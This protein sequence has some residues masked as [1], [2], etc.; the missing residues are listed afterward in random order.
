[1]LTLHALNTYLEGSGFYRATALLGAAVGATLAWMVPA[2]HAY[3]PGLFL[4]GFVAGGFLVGF[5]RWLVTRVRDLVL[6]GPQLVL[7][8]LAQT[9]R[10]SLEFTVSGTSA[11]DA[12]HVN[13]AFRAWAGPREDRPLEIYPGFINLRTVIWGVGLFSLVLCLLA[14][15]RLDMLNVLLLLP[16][17]LFSVSTVAGPFL[18]T[19]PSGKPLGVRAIIPRTLGWAGAAA[20]YF[21]VSVSATQGKAGRWLALA[22]FLGVFG[23]LLR[24][25]LRYFSFR[26]RLQTGR[27]RLERLIE[28]MLPGSTTA[29]GGGAGISG[30]RSTTAPLTETRK[31][32]QVILQTSLADPARTTTILG[33]TGIPGPEQAVVRDF[34]ETELLPLLRGP[35]LDLKKG[36]LAQSRWVAEYNR[37]FVLGLLVLLWFFLV[38]VPGLMVFAAGSYPES[39]RFTLPLAKVL[40]TLGLGIAFALITFWAGRVVQWLDLAG[41]RP[42]ALGLRLQRCSAAILPLPK[43]SSQTTAQDS[44]SMDSPPSPLTD[45]QTSA[46]F[47]LLTDAQTYIDQRSYAY[48]RRAIEQAE[49]KVHSAS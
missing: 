8:A 33:Q 24:R 45:V 47:A 14:L 40:A 22:L 15:T 5:S 49:R 41:S 10:L 12:R 20:F 18:M 1:V 17:L 9:V 13:L 25:A 35:V 42:R 46:A 27:R 19:H 38:P 28:S 30:S 36:P 32:S 7:H 29:L 39:Y 21:V 23:L 2:W 31:I 26:R 4:L 3:A 11:E 16:S 44:Q 48:A 6:F 43:S 34:V 37:A